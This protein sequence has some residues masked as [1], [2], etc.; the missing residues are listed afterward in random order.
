MFIP[1]TVS[2]TST[3]SSESTTVDDVIV[4]GSV[5]GDD[6]V[7]GTP[8]MAH[9]R[10]ITF[11]ATIESTNS[12]LAPPIPPRT[13]KMYI[14]EHQSSGSAKNVP[15]SDNLTRG[16]FDREEHIAEK[17]SD[18]ESMLAQNGDAETEV[19]GDADSREYPDDTISETSCDIGFPPPIPWRTQDM[20]CVQNF[21]SSDCTAGHITVMPNPSY[22]GVHKATVWNMLLC[23]HPSIHDRQD[24]F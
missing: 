3:A 11:T 1:A 19:D 22:M 12:D 7:N 24:L 8:N 9:C 17:G 13:N 20:F 21:D 5:F 16:C 4:T 14:L 2:S 10:T 23:L 15:L 18:T 6:S